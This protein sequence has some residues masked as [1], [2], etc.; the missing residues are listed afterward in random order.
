MKQDI[1]MLK[2][3]FQVRSENLPQIT[4][5]S[6]LER[7]ERA[8]LFARGFLD[9]FPDIDTELRRDLIHDMKKAYGLSD[10]EAE[11]ILSN[12]LTELRRE[13][14]RANSMSETMDQNER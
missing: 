1:D 7:M 10:R 8:A 11:K 9:S 2:R 13:N 12:V 6:S 3:E 5:A 14:D 4:R